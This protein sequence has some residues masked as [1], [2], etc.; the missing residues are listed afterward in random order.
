[1]T[2]ETTAASAPE[3]TF[4]CGAAFAEARA[5]PGEPVYARG[6]LPSYV[7][8]VDAHWYFMAVED[9]EKRHWVSDQ[10]VADPDGK[11]ISIKF[12]ELSPGEALVDPV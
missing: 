5:N 2:E 12:I 6:P 8:N 3:I 11:G 10:I 7:E 9:A 1:M 4:N